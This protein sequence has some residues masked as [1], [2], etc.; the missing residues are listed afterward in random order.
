MKLALCIRGHLR[1]GLFSSE[2]ARYCDTLVE[3]GHEVD[4]YLHTWKR[5]EA[6]LSYRRLDQSHVF[7]VT[8]E[9]LRCYFKAHPIC[10]LIIQDETKIRGKA[11]DAEM[12]STSRCP[13]LAWRRMWAGQ[14]ACIQSVLDS[15]KN[16]DLAISLRYD[17]FTHSLALGPLSHCCRALTQKGDIIFKYPIYSR[18][19]VGVD[20]FFAGRP[21]AMRALIFDFHMHL[22]KI[23]AQYPNVCHQEEI[24]YR[25][26]QDQGLL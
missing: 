1:D 16:Y 6:L 5:S 13:K 19:I 3:T 14:A 15:G 25:Y 20:N 11:S 10:N 7:T 9:L 4:L 8:P 22:D 12:I 2:M 18:S 26:T 23:L 24:V 21:E 17:N